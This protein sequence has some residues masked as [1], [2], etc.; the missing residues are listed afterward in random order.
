MK[1]K[2]KVTRA[3]LRRPLPSQMPKPEKLDTLRAQQAL[4][5]KLARRKSQPRSLGRLIAEGHG[6]EN[7]LGSYKKSKLHCRAKAPA[8][9]PTRL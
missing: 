3:D 4:A 5:S 1:P 9:I 8:H 2:A 6:L 7:H